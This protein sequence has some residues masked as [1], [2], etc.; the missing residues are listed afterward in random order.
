MADGAGRSCPIHYR[1]RP[2]ALMAE[3]ESWSEEVLYV[4]LSLIHI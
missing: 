3:P 1:Y 4:V 2:E